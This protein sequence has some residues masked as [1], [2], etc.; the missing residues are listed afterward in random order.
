MSLTVRVSEAGMGTSLRVPA[1]ETGLEV[2]L[3]LLEWWAAKSGGEKL[4]WL[5]AI[6]SLALYLTGHLNGYS[7]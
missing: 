3:G 2:K 4:T 1:K 7:D 5:I 6:G